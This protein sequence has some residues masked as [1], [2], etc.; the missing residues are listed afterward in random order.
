MG[1]PDLTGVSVLIVEDHEDSRE[2]LTMWLT[3]LGASVSE[4]CDAIE[5]LAMVAKAPPPSVIL[6]DI[7]LPGMSG[8]SF[9]ARLREQTNC[10]RIPVIAVTGDSS[11]SDR[12]RE[13]GFAALMV[14]PVTG[15]V[16]G[17]EI[18]RVLST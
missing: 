3:H 8:L 17:A 10:E 7:H 18:V 1:A 16:L 2:A 5:A 13:L 9:L 12:L 15:K 14:K 11:I 6:C 4:A